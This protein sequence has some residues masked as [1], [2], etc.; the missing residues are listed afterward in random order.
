M[1]AVGEWRATYAPGDWLVLCGPT[2]VVVL[3]PPGAGWT[4]LTAALWDEVLAAASLVELAARLAAYGLD[5]MPSFGALFWT[6]EGM[7]SLVRG[8]VRVVDPATGQVVADGEGV[9]TWRESGLAGLTTARLEAGERGEPDDDVLLLPLVVGAVRASSVLL[10]ARAEARVDSPQTA[11]P[12]AAGPE[13][14]ESAP[15]L[16]PTLSDPGEPSLELPTTEAMPVPAPL[17]GP[18]GEQADDEDTLP[19]AT[20]PLGEESEDEESGTQL[21]PSTPEEEPGPAAPTGPTVLAVLCPYGHPNPPGTARCSDCG[22]RVRDEELRP[23]PQPALATLRVSD[24]TQ[25][26][27]D[28]L[29]RVGRAPVARGDVPSGLLTVPSPSHDI[30]RTHLEIAP[31]GWQV[32]VRDLNSTNGTILVSPDGSSRRPLPPGEAV[33]VA[34]GSVLELADGIS[35]LLDVLP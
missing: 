11:V 28:R 29:V 25:V 18:K 9:Q 22:V 32:L 34:L 8:R 2:S 26:V 27:L 23:V 7:H 21:V 16:E 10:D 24:G 3:E 6:G 31:E 15:A 30:S 19:D 17:A 14:E 5:S 35:V 33:P 4:A 1:T 13:E 12:A 20:E